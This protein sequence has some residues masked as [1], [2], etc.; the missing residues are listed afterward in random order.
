MNDSLRFKSGF[1]TII[2]KP[3][4][5]K[6]TLLN[7]IIGENISITSKKAQTTRK[8][9]K[10]I[11]NDKNLQI[12][13]VDTPG[14]HKINNKLDEYMD[15]SIK[16]SL[17]D[18][19]LLLYLVD[20]NNFDIENL[21]NEF[22][23]VKHL[24]QIKFLLI[25]KIDVLSYNIDKQKKIIDENIDFLKK[26]FTEIIYISSLKNKNINIL[27]DKIK[28]YLPYGPI[29]YDQN[30]ITDETEK[31]IVAE[32]IRQQCLYKINDEIPHG[33]IVNIDKFIDKKNICH[34][35]ANIIC[36]KD[37]HKGIIIGKN[38]SMIKNIGIGSR[39]MIEKLL[40][41]KVNL[42]TYVSVKTN[43]RNTLSNLSNY[44][45]DKKHI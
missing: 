6:S 5:G 29:Y 24:K 7:C 13:F 35:D 45:F 26:I 23:K 37:S 2:G 21:K 15:L 36:E 14:I 44:G 20:I 11:Y 31:S 16:K 22:K 25:N 10:G 43:W 30:N 9:I 17:S 39:I 27:I 19:D 4:V 38:G 12:V 8:N 3:N 18:I 1:V 33:I 42:K 40:N 28:K 32:Y 41:K 34:I